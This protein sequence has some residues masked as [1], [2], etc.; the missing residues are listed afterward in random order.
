MGLDINGILK[1]LPHRSPFLL[2]DRVLEV[3][4]GQH[5]RA[6]KNLSY[7]ESYF[8]GH[9]PHRPL[10]PGVLIIEALAQAAG[11]LQIVS[12]ELTPSKV[13][14]S[15]LVG[16]DKTRFRKPVGP[17]DQLLLCVRRE[18]SIGT[19]SCFSAVARVDD[20]EVASARLMMAGHAHTA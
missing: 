15:Y 6:V 4:A 8:S 3:R 5:I 13:G 16:M 10:M 1:R 9:F 7:N 17:G 11:I 18:R 12:A 14:S 19:I 2:V 20:H